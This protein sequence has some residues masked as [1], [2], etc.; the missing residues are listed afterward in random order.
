MLE[1]EFIRNCHEGNNKIH[2]CLLWDVRPGMFA[3]KT[4][5][6]YILRGQTQIN[7]FDYADLR[8]QMHCQTA[9]AKKF[10]ISKLI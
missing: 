8:C 10:T 9:K 2:L 4:S 3:Q 5:S 7:F 1:T 6:P